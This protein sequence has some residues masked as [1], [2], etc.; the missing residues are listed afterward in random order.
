MIQNSTEYKRAVDTLKKW[1]YAYYVLDNPLVPDETYDKLYEDVVAYETAHPKDIDPTSP[2]QRVGAEPAKE[3]KKVKHLAK[4]WSMEDVFSQEGLQEWMRRSYKRAQ[5][6]DLLFY[7]EPKFDGLSLNLIYENGILISGAT[8]G[9]GVIGEDVTQNAK[10]IPSVPL[11]IDYKELIEIR[12]EVVIKKDDFE[13]LNK[14]RIQKGETPFANPR[15]AAAGSLRQLD[16]RVT[17]KRELFFYPWGVGENSLHYESMYD[18]MSFVYSLGFIPAFKRA[19]CKDIDAIEK[20]YEEFREVRDSLPVML[21]GMAIKINNIALHEKLGYTVKYPRWMVAYKF[22]ALEKMTTL[23]KVLP[24]VGRTGLVTPVA[25][26]KP[27][28]VKGV[29]VEKATLHNYSEIEKKD[30]R[31]GDRVII[32]RSGDVIPEITKV[33]KQYRTGKEKKIQRPKFCPVCKE[34]LLDEGLLI[35]CQ[36]LNCPARIVNSL[37]YFSSQQCLDIEGLGQSTVEL[38]YDKGLVKDFIDIF[39]LK[40]EDLLKLPHFGKKRAE[41]LLQ[42]IENVKGVQCWRFVNALGIEHIGEVASR[43]LCQKFGLHWYKATLSQIEE[44]EGFGFQMA[45]SIVEFVEVNRDEIEKLIE[46]I[47]PKSPSQRIVKTFFTGK[48][49]VL[50][51]TMRESREKIKETLES[52]GAHVSD[53]VS[54]RDDFVFYGKNPGSKYEKAKE[55]GVPLLPE[56]K[57][58]EMIKGAK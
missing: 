32:I 8:R 55:F 27:V 31:I 34:A 43:K 36:N 1:A 13:R 30:L 35:K 56:T 45:Q 26:V 48:T 24:Q 17:A 39:Y 50:T 37:A 20:E 42:A 7:I 10:T 23:L 52:L 14:Q 4:M 57:M 44:I 9:D 49:V 58:W 5:T 29:M 22:P 16:P 21:D 19:L 33:L 12:G 6:E 40:E 28:E 53:S 46:I 2:T 54:K 18:L 11:G 41:H 47:Q 51:G 38:L 15:N 25:I 3:F